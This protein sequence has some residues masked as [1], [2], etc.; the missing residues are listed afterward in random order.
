MNMLSDAPSG[1]KR[2]LVVTFLVNH[3][4]AILLLWTARKRAAEIGG[5][6]RVV[7]IDTPGVERDQSRTRQEQTLHLLTRAK[8]MGAETE[9]VSSFSVLKGMEE[10][11]ARDHARISTV[12]VGSTE[13]DSGLL[14]RFYRPLW[15]KQVELVSK[16]NRVETIPL[17]G[18]FQQPLLERIMNGIKEIQ[19]RHMIYA[20]LAMLIPYGIAV[21]MQSALPPAFFRIN[22]ENIDNLFLIAA[23]IAA[24][25]FGL[26]P[27]IVA[28]FAGFFINHYFFT[29]PYGQFKLTGLTDLFGMVLFLTAAILIA[30]FTSQMRVYAQRIKKREMHTEFLFTL[31]RLTSESFSREQAI[32]TLEKNLSSM[33]KADVAFFL[34]PAGEPAGLEVA[35]ES[36]YSFN[37]NDLK[38]L[39]ACWADMKT[40]GAAAPY[41][42]GSEWRF[43]PMI[44]AGGEVGVLGVRVHEHRSLD[45][46]FGRLLNATAD[47]TAAILAHIQLERS[48]EQ[49]R[50][51]E[52]REKLRVMLLSSVSHDL[53]TPLA[54]IIGALSTYNTLK[55]RLKPTQQKELL[56]CSLEEAQ[57]LDSLISNILDMT[58]LEA[59]NIKFHREWHNIRELTESVVKRLAHRIKARELALHFPGIEI[60]AR[61]DN[62]MTG[63]V[64]QNLI[65][66]AC[67]YT[68]MGTKIE[69]SW[70]TDEDH[71]LICQVR[72]HGTGIPP[73]KLESVFDKY[74]RLQKQDMQTPGTGLG[75]AIAR[76]VI[77]GQGGWI[78]AANHPDGGAVFTFYLPEWRPAT[79]SISG[80]EKPYATL[81]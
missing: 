47:Q 29:L 59:G 3:P 1:G 30:I 48:M 61:L 71:G 26:A 55:D 46:W 60:E 43:E 23:A 5:I 57:R 17:A 58:R 80:R 69:V 53:K 63:Q 18:Q 44:A 39:S 50:I 40:T 49:T 65:D 12:I 36:R 52:E 67:K 51:S 6:W 33:L 73:E 75:L 21:A 10:M 45:A 4:K 16:Y 7:Y 8:Q 34:P 35:G 42:P 79:T 31:Y 78:R 22:E 15:V 28:A 2:D 68:P 32:E 74:T 76:S 41:D 19:P 66:N 64:L 72:D 25:R 54:G 27:G 20:L 11:L 24:G 62:I 37:E 38:A 70:E 81:Q 13:K 9:H 77:E 56:D 14:G